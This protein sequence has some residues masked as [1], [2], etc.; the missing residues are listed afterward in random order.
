MSYEAFFF[1]NWKKLPS[2]QRYE[3]SLSDCNG[4]HL[5][6]PHFNS[7]FSVRSPVAKM[8]RK[9]RLSI[10]CDIEESEEYTALPSTKAAKKLGHDIVTQ[11]SPICENISGMPLSK[12]CSLIQNSQIAERKSR[13]KAKV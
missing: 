4:C 6:L 3:H 1:E 12:L 11:L 2:V 8:K 9:D 5:N 10:T 13:T 7:A